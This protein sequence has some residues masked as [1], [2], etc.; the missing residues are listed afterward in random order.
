MVINR[1]RILFVCTEEI[2]ELC[3]GCIYRYPQLI[4][5]TACTFFELDIDKCVNNNMSYKADF[6]M[7]GKE[8]KDR[9]HPNIKFLKL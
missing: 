7:A 8:R 1:N 3:N 9:C 4:A 6:G 5:H 2:K